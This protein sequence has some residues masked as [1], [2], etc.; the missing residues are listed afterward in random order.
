[1]L[2]ATDVQGW[3][4]MSK[5]KCLANI[6]NMIVAA[7]KGEESGVN[8]VAHVSANTDK[9][10]NGTEHTGRRAELDQTNFEIY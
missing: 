7:N 2:Q 3:E 8:S 4:L 5:G 1:M 9:S 10:S 6:K